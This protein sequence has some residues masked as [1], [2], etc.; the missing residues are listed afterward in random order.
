MSHIDIDIIDF[1]LL[2]IY[3]VI[4]L[5]IIEIIYKI[6]KIYSRSKL[7]FQASTLIIFAASYLIMIEPHWL[8]STVLFSLAIA[9][10]YQYKNFNK[11]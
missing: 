9:L 11:H 6:I 3:P 10:L 8:T 1:I 2:T 7:L 5:L 4:S